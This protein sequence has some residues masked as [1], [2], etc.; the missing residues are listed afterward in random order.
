MKRC[1]FFCALLALPALAQ[2]N[3]ARFA[4]PIRMGNLPN[5]TQPSLGPGTDLHLEF[6][7]FNRALPN[8]AQIQAVLVYDSMFWGTSGG[9]WTP[10]KGG[11]WWLR[12]A[13]GRLIQS[14]QFD[15]GACGWSTGDGTDDGS[16]EID[17]YDFSLQEPDG[18]IAYAGEVME[19]SPPQG[20]HNEGEY[21]DCPTGDT[22]PESFTISDGKGFSATVSGDY[23]SVSGVANDGY[24]DDVTNGLTD[25]DGNT[26]SASSTSLADAL[27]TA[28][29]I[30]GAGT[31]SSPVTY[32]YTGPN[33]TP[34]TVTV[35]YESTPMRMNFGCYTNWSGNVNLPEAIEYPD[36][37]TY[38]FSYGT[39]GFLTSVT[40]PSGGTTYY[41]GWYLGVECSPFYVT[42]GYAE[43]NSIDGVNN[44][45]SFTYNSSTSQ[46]TRRDPLGE[47]TISSFDGSGNLTGEDTY[48]GLSNNSFRVSRTTIG[49]TPYSRTI[50]TALCSH[51]YPADPCS[52]SDTE[53]L[54]SQHKVTLDGY[55]FTTATSTTDWGLNTPGA[56]LRQTANTYNVVG[57]GEVPA[58]S[59]IEDGSG[60]EAAKTVWSYGSGVN[61][62]SETDYVNNG[63]GLTTSYTWNANGTLATLTSP[64]GAVTTFGYTCGAGFYPSSVQTVLGT[65]TSSWDCNGGS[66]PRPPISMDTVHRPASTASGG[67]RPRPMPPA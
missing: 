53:Q 44:Q 42:S 62:A 10:Q 58:S 32:T 21:W 18:S 11:G 45:W 41:T 56:L 55:G 27:G 43:Y 24:G 9:A 13:G 51:V 39:T 3:L 19:S 22:L 33:N 59:E 35:L 67:P 47:D 48:L 26:M 30:A 40:A 37:A 49:G 15:Y 54:Q 23:F 65:T 50:T 20:L 52:A 4:G 46:S 57:N 28:V 34:E 66:R 16:G 2:V 36:G 63:G 60:N 5:A 7:I 8:R 29:T 25:P 31:S 61:P 6:P 64:T 17:Y 1:L 14:N 12:T 38:T